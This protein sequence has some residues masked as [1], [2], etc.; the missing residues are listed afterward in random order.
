MNNII[1]IPKQADGSHERMGRIENLFA[2]LNQ[3]DAEN[4]LPRGAKLKR[5]LAGVAMAGIG[6]LGLGYALHTPDTHM[7]GTGVVESPDVNLNGQGTSGDKNFDVAINLVNAGIAD[8]K[9]QGINVSASQKVREEVAEIVTP[10]VAKLDADPSPNV[11]DIDESKYNFVVPI[12]N[13]EIAGAQ[14]VAEPKQ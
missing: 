11:F 2:A 5:T 14:F 12:E 10:M 9:E 6:A 1:K 13:G 7:N 8:A 4:G 3:R